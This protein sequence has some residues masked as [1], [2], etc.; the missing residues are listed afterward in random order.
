MLAIP[1]PKRISMFLKGYADL[2]SIIYIFCVSLEE[3]ANTF[4]LVKQQS[5]KKNICDYGYDK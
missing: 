2:Y 3:I 1:L 4:L 5:T